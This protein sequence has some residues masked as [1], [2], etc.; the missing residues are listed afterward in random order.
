VA[1]VQITIPDALV[2]RLAAA[3]DATFPQY[4]GLSDAAAFKQITSDY[5]RGILSEHEQ[6]DAERAA[7]AANALAIKAAAE[8]AATDGAGIV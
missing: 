4:N 3:M 6:R 5:W 2:P 8:K 7:Q 1:T